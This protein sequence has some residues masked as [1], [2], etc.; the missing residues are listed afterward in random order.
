MFIAENGEFDEEVLVYAFILILRYLD[1]VPE[2]CPVHFLKLAATAVFVAHKILLDSGL[3]KIADFA[4]IAGLSVRSVK[5]LELEFMEEID[6][7][8]HVTQK[9]YCN[10]HQ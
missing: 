6:F 10:L 4:E 7:N 8:L 5:S 3:W 2:D 1:A 9:E